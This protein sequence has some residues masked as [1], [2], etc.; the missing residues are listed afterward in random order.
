MLMLVASARQH[1]NS[2][3]SGDAL[4]RQKVS[5]VVSLSLYIDSLMLPRRWPN[6]LLWLCHVSIVILNVI[7][8][9]DAVPEPYMVR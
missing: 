6:A 7:Q 9:N 8:T 1:F 5:E 2:S 4:S 3:G